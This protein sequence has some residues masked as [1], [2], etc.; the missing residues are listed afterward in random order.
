MKNKFIGPQFE[1]DRYCLRNHSYIS[2]EEWR[3]CHKCKQLGQTY[4]PDQPLQAYCQ[5]MIK[6]QKLFD[7]S[8][9]EEHL[10]LGQYDQRKYK[11][12]RI[13]T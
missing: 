2:L 4:H 10:H 1:W 12:N 6:L 8:T 11:L 13:L 3:S 9:F 5:T 7:D